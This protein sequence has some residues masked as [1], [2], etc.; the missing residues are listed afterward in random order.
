MNAIVQH[1]Y[2][3]PEAL[4]L[5]TLDTPR[6][7]PGEVLVRV[8]AASLH[9]GDAHLM[10]GT[11]YVVRLM[12][13]GLRRPKAGTPGT[14]VA[15]HVEAVGPGVTRWRPGD[16]VLGLS[17]G[18]LAELACARE[19]ALAPRPANLT[20][21]QAAAVPTSALAALRALRDRGGVR[22]GR[23]V[24]V[25]GASGGVGAFAVQIAKAL[26]A[27]VTGVCSTGNVDMVRSLGADRVVDYTRAD[28]ARGG[29]RYDL[30]V[31]AV[32]S[33]SLS[34]LRRAL[35]AQGTLVL[36]GG[37]GGRVLGGLGRFLRAAALSPF[38]R[39]R[40]R[41]SLPSDSGTAEDLGVLV[42]MIESG[43]LTPVIDRLYDLSEAPA[44]I[45]YLERG[46]ARGKVVI[47]VDSGRTLT[48]APSA[49]A[50]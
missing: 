7:G 15:G 17:A 20:F 32:G 23:R 29:E 33:R 14:D 37:R 5:E 42:D 25:V 34:D 41:P 10:R 31:D 4:G 38:V 49:S 19:D 12:G 36:V 47:T 1:A 9:P 40:L 18:A 6:I 13:F 3:P 24:L 44:A 2:G 46:H 50:I 39:Q 27:E 26:G 8:R 28:V 16:E 30:V 45:R 22:A 11:P 21:E 48:G 35:T 43:R